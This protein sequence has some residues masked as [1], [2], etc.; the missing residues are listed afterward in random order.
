MSAL[1]YLNNSIYNNKNSNK[2]VQEKE[3]G[4]CS[5]FCM[6][7]NNATNQG[8]ESIQGQNGAG[9]VTK[10]AITADKMK[11]A[12]MEKDDMMLSEGAAG[13]AQYEEAYG[14]S[15]SG[16]G[17]AGGQFNGVPAQTGNGTIQPRKLQGNKT[18]EGYYGSQQQTNEDGTG[19]G[20]QEIDGGSGAP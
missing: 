17:G 4:N 12:Y 1:E 18:Q 19:M 10:K 9:G 16:R 2:E 3:M 11:Q 13:A 14:Q 15:R 7:S 8:E 20:N 6:T 5:G